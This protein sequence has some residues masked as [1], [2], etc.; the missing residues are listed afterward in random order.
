M[1]P[2]ACTHVGLHEIDQW[3]VTPG[4]YT[5]PCTRWRRKQSAAA[6]PGEEHRGGQTCGAPWRVDVGLLLGPAGVLGFPEQVQRESADLLHFLRTGSD[7]RYWDSL[8][9]T[10]LASQRCLMDRKSWQTF[11]VQHQFIVIYLAGYTVGHAQRKHVA[12]T[13]KVFFP[14]YEWKI[15]TFLSS[16]REKYC[17]KREDESGSRHW[18]KHS[19]IL[20]NTEHEFKKFVKK[21]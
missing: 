5:V 14:L 16:E 17:N 13:A 3:L 1:C 18:C 20:K 9:A 4:V 19:R 10:G 8:T 6:P 7:R 15:P 12:K 2:H 21:E 11:K